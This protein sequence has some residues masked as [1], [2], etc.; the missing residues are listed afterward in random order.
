MFNVFEVSILTPC[1]MDK[2][3]LKISEVKLAVTFKRSMN[4]YSI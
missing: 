1:L 4:M 2:K 3:W